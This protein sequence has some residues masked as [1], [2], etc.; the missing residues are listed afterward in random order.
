[1]NH[2]SK[3]TERLSAKKTVVIVDKYPNIEYFTVIIKNS[4]RQHNDHRT[5]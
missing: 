5:M 4:E 1:M 2:Y 3:C